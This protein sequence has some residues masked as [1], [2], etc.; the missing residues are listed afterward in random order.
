MLSLLRRSRYIITEKT[1][2]IERE[3][4]KEVAE[5]MGYHRCHRCPNLLLLCA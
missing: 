4:K 5:S 1:E 3:R 2:K